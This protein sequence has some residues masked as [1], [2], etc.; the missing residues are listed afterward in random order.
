MPLLSA[1][2]PV[3][4]LRL[5]GRTSHGERI[6]RSI[7]AGLRDQF[8]VTEGSRYEALAFAEAMKLARIKYAAERAANQ[9]FPDTASVLLA[10]HEADRGLVPAWNET[11]QARRTALAIRWRRPKQPTRLEV[12]GAL[13]D[14]L[15]DDF[16][17]LVTT[18]A[19]DTQ[20]FP[21]GIA[22]SPSNL[23]PYGTTRRLLRFLGPVS[24]LYPTLSTVEYEL[25]GSTGR[26]DASDAISADERLV[27]EA[28][29]PGITERVT[30]E[31]VSSEE[32]DDGS[33]RR[34]LSARFNRPHHAGCLA[35]TGNFPAQWSS[36]RHS[37]VVVT[38]AAAVDREKRRRVNE[39]LNRV[40]RATS[41]WSIVQGNEGSTGSFRIGESPI[42]A[43][44]LGDVSY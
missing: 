7:V 38:P 26:A 44:T 40:A 32:L 16:L 39:Y 2:T 30:I 31:D 21:T 14:L 15:G 25:V 24:F 18:A 3:G 41:T 28:E 42:A 20:V 13:T 33:V 11:T 27:V 29:V 6:Y 19:A 37:L 36:K 12:E 8:D 23:V 22:V 9:A 5:S 17:A 10:R 43:Q 4:M 1:F 35:S 34:F